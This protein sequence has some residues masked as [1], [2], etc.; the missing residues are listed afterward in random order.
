LVAQ[1][2]N[3]S[4]SGGRDWEKSQFETPILINGWVLW[5][6]PIIPGTRRS[7]NR[8]TAVQVSLALSETLSQK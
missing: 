7:T 4:Y 6:M 5:Y 8:K 3:P 1:T 2:Y